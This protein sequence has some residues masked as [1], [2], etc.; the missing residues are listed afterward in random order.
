MRK[1]PIESSFLVLVAGIFRRARTFRL[2]WAR[3]RWWWARSWARRWARTRAAVVTAGLHV[4]RRAVRLEF[5]RF[6]LA[7]FLERRHQLLV[8]GTKRI[9]VL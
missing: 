4:E 9:A 2:R 7:D 1:I 6:Q 8:V 5:E 3:T